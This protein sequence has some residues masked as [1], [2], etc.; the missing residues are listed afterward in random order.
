MLLIYDV[1][2]YF[3][4]INMDIINR[5]RLSA[6]NHLAN[7]ILCRICIFFRSISSSIE[8]NVIIDHASG[9]NVNL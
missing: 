3:R 7:K 5:T 9:R 4:S 2:K 1:C 6:S 8:T